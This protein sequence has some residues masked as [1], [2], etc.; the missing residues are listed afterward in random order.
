MYAIKEKI[1]SNIGGKQ[2]GKETHI[3]IDWQSKK[4]WK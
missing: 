3:S 2:F 4:K 1:Y